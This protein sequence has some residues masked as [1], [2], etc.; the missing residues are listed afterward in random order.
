[1]Q[2]LEMLATA[3]M[4][5]KEQEEEETEGEEEVQEG[6]FGLDAT[7]PRTQLRMFLENAAL[8]STAEDPDQEKA[9][10]HSAALLRTRAT[11]SSASRRRPPGS[12][13][14]CF[15]VKASRRSSHF[16]WRALQ[17]RNGGRAVWAEP[18]A[19]LA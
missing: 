14:C 18:R 17:A 3:E 6:V 16:R 4:A 2:L 13:P 11:C 7:D 5:E 8:V 1:M 19:R 15:H 10:V 12:A 9:R